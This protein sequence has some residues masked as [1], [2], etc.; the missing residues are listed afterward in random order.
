M[1]REE[2]E[3]TLEEFRKGLETELALL[4]QLQAVA[5][6]QREVSAARDFDTFKIISDERDR[7]TRSL[8]A[9][10]QG[11][12]ESRDLL[13]NV[14]DQ[15]ASIP[16]Y[17]TVLALRQA[18]TDLVNDILSCDRAAMKALADAEV[19]RRAAMASLERGETTLAAYRRVLAPPVSNAGLVD[20]RG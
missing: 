19:A 12:G 15:A 13:T 8:L 2:L 20:R 16:A 7:L 1:T 14:R 17:G 4:R 18:S 5:A 6:R 3:L 9:I 11:L 10:E